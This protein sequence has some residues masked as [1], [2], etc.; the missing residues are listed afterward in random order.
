MTYGY[1][2]LPGIICI[3]PGI[4]YMAGTDGMHV[5]ATAV[6]VVRYNAGYVG[7]VFSA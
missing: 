4:R 2:A 1:V 5:C 6:P 3:I 7:R